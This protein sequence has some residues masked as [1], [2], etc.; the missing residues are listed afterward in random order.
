MMFT[1]DDTVTHTSSAT[2]QDAWPESA[3]EHLIDCLYVYDPLAIGFDPVIQTVSGQL[4][5]QCN[6]RQ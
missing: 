3:V 6:T 1:T 5:V 4:L 2:R